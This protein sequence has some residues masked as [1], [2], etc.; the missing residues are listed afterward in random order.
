MTDITDTLEENSAS[1][2][3]ADAKA[4]LADIGGGQRLQTH[5]GNCHKWHSTC[6]VSKLTREIERLRTPATHATPTQGSVQGEG[7]DTVGQRLVERLSIT[8]AMLDDNEKLRSE[9]ASLREA[10]RR[11]AEQDATLSVCDG[12]V[13]VTMD[14]TLTDEEKRAVGWAA[15]MMEVGS[16]PNSLNRD[17]ARTLRALLERLK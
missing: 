3:V 13:T 17:D 14:G 7:T 8:Q 15:E 10:I 12:N 2:I 1:D 11:L 4:W 5:S 6:L 16:L 9:I